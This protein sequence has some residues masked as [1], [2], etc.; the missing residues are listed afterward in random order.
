MAIAHA[1]NPIIGSQHDRAVLDGE[2]DAD[3]AA[4]VRGPHHALD[5]DT[6]QVLIHAAHALAEQ[7]LLPR[8]RGVDVV[9]APVT[10]VPGVF[11][12]R[13]VHVSRSAAAFFGGGDGEDL[14][15]GREEG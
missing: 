10:D 15:G 8:C 3:V 4:V 11:F 1:T 6:Q 2:R 13:G 14:A 9:G 12:V 5:V 7:E